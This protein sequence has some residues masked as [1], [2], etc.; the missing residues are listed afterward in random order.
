MQDDQ[1]TLVKIG[2][3]TF[4]TGDTT[5]PDVAKLVLDGQKV[6]VVHGGGSTVNH[7]LN[8]LGVE[9]HFLQGL[10]I[11]DEATL[12]V[13]T[14][15]LAGIVN[16]SLVIQL[17]ASG[18]NAVGLS[19][20]DGGLLAGSPL[21]SQFGNVAGEVESNP[22]IIFDLLK[23]GITPVVAPLALNL[24]KA[25]SYLNVNADTAAGEIARAI[26]AAKLVFMT[27][28]D[29]ILDNEGEVIKT[30]PRNSIEEL[31]QEGVLSGGMI[32]KVNACALVAEIGIV[33]AIINGTK[34]GA[35]VSWFS[36]LDI[37][38]SVV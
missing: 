8:R 24:I 29:G 9:S 35:L 30:L 27:D 14:G 20:V 5:L 1:I 37:G 33:A 15:V 34:N 10:R 6:V 17:R 26:E 16:K 2:G 21:G 38:T 4:A 28:V 11:T 7:W 25:N 3:S 19:G 31:I 13:V 36:G 12:E 22:T 23:A 32:P 18:V